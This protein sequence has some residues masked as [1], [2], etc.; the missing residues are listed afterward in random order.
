MN[1]E[2]FT[3]ILWGGVIFAIPFLLLAVFLLITPSRTSGRTD[4][5]Y[6]REYHDPHSR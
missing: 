3:A 2:L 5:T 6:R 1:A 4:T